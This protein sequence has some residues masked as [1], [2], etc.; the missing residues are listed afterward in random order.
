M[1]E[2]TAT[3][4]EAQAAHDAIH[5]SEDHKRAEL[6]MQLPVQSVLGAIDRLL[7]A[8][9][10]EDV[11]LCASCLI[12]ATW[13]TI[14]MNILL[15]VAGGDAHQGEAIKDFIGFL[16]EEAPVALAQIAVEEGG[17]GRA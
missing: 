15:R 1:T 4:D 9:E 17:G 13:A 8:S 3:D 2:T 10:N 5:N 7:D 12:R 14:T 16:E 11:D 6:M